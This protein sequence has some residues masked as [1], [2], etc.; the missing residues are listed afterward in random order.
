MAQLL[1]EIRPFNDQDYNAL[2]DLMNAVYPEYRTTAEGLKEDDKFFD[3]QGKY[4]R[5]RYV[6]V[7]LQTGE[8]VGYASISHMPRAFHLQKFQMELM[9]HPER[10]KQGVGSKLYERLVNDLQ[11]LNAVSVKTWVFEDRTEAITFLQRRG[12][13]EVFRSWELKLD[14]NG[15]DL[16][17]FLPAVERVA[18]QGISIT[19]LSA[20]FQ[21]DPECLPKLYELKRLIVQDIPAPDQITFASYEEFVG[22]MKHSEFLPDAYFIAKD[23]NRYIG[24]SNL[25]RS[26]GEPEKLYQ[27]V[28][29]ILREYRRRGIATALKVKT[30]EYARNHGYRFIVTQNASVNIEMLTL[31]EKL[32]FKRSVGIIT[33]ERK[34]AT[35]AKD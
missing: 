2:S 15:C 27:G 18:S 5:H 17:A 35:C 22:Y 32:G 19:T 8:L 10:R 30:I 6:A 4:L 3:L 13:E 33:M 34:I 21:A 28:T 20:E 11:E 16:Q 1:V 12:F 14:V 23:G 24:I 29:G 26:K 9:V 31:N 25:W 7:D